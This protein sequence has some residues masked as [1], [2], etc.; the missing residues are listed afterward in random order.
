MANGPFNYVNHTELLLKSYGAPW[1]LAPADLLAAKV[2]ADAANRAHVDATDAVSD[3]EVNT[4][5]AQAQWEA[6]ARTAVSAGRPLPSRDPLDRA[7]ITLDLAR[8]DERRTRQAAVMAVGALAN[9]LNDPDTREAWAAAVHPR[10]DQLN[11]LLEEHTR[12]LAPLVRETIDD[13]ALVNFLTRWTHVQ[14]M[15]L[16]VHAD[17]IGGLRTIIDLRR[18]LPSGTGN[19]TA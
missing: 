11:D 1:D 6:D 12:A 19:I 9:E 16:A 2:A 4:P 3:G 14:G 8:E 5:G 10:I 13:V 15:G 17:P 18:N 7:R